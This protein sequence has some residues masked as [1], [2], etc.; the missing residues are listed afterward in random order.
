MIG[1][2]DFSRSLATTAPK[3]VLRTQSAKSE[4]AASAYRAD[5]TTRMYRA[6]Q[7]ARTGDEITQRLQDHAD[8]N[9]HTPIMTRA[10]MQKLYPS[11]TLNKNPKTPWLSHQS[12]RQLGPN[13]KVR[14]FLEMLPNET[15]IPQFSSIVHGV[16]EHTP[17]I[18]KLP[19]SNYMRTIQRAMDPTIA[20]K[21]G[22]SR[23]AH[24]VR[25]RYK[26]YWDGA[27]DGFANPRGQG[28]VLSNLGTTS[29]M[30][31]ASLYGL[32]YLIE[33]EVVKSKLRQEDDKHAQQLQNTLASPQPAMP[34]L[35]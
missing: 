6:D 31:S 10:Q 29:V 22:L 17:E 13:D 23:I 28:S 34:M 1:S 8:K 18:E 32:L 14:L 11:L 30:I 20:G 27:K 4:N 9:I 15:A 26:Q 21:T 3:N 25:H 33:Y 19:H 16:A 12:G 24:E 35:G 5:A 2:I 7:I